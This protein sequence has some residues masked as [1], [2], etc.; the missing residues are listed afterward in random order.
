MFENLKA[1]SSRHIFNLWGWRTNRKL[2]IIESDDWGSIRMPS[3][4]IYNKCLNNG[5]RV[6]QNSYERYDSLLSEEDLNNLFDVLSGYKDHTGNHPVITANCVVAN[7]D[8]EKI[9][10]DNFK[11]YHFELVSETFKRYPNHS[12]NLNIWKQGIK[13][14]IFFP[15]FHAREHINVSMLM[16]ALQSGNRDA[17]F[18]FDNNMAGSIM[19][20]NG[21]TDNYFVAASDYHS[22]SD[23]ADKL[24]LF[25]EGLDLFETIFG[26]RSQTLIPPNYIWSPD[27]DKAVSEKG[28]LYY[29]GIRKIKEPIPGHKPKYHNH[30]MG[31]QNALGQTYLIRNAHFEPSISAKNIDSIVKR[32]LSDIAIA[33]RM[34]KPA[35]ICSHRINY[36][37]YINES[38]RDR[39]LKALSHLIAKTL[40]Q[41]PDVEFVNSAELGSLITSKDRR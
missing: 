28:V 21:N 27:F 18:G 8:F 23:K 7:P 37:G 9:R 5:Y 31:K 3:K 12:D 35:I 14:K 24:N 4:D 19:H 34:K 10:N 20:G 25:L 32:C 29:Q 26:Y 41:W 11:N 16:N 6:D 2:V 13:E 39:T 40:R 22:A 17:L 33:F 38:N 15:Q 1:N 30:Y 36:V